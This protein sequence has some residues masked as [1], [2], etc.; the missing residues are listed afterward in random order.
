MVLQ[1]LTFIAVFCKSPGDCAG[2]M[3]YRPSL[4]LGTLQLQVCKHQ[5]LKISLLGA[6]GQKRVL[7]EIPHHAFI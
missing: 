4:P 5:A 3:G 1:G 7:K 2:S 6:V